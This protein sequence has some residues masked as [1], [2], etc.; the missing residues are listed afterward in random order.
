MPVI[1]ILILIIQIGFAAH[2]IRR[3]H[4]QIWIYLIIFVPLIGCLLYTLMVLL[5]EARSSLEIKKGICF[6]PD[7]WKNW[8]RSTRRWRN[9]KPFVNIIVVRKPNVVMGFY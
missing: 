5:P 3:G 1:G 7:H 2:A 4:D 8:A 9:T 6:M